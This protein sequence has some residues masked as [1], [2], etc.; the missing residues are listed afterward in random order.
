MKDFSSNQYT[1]ST[2]IKKRQNQRSTCARL[3]RKFFF[4]RDPALTQDIR[5]RVTSVIYLKLKITLEK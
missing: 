4:F 2:M 5:K 1:I 3:E